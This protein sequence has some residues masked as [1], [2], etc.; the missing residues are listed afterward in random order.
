MAKLFL[1]ALGLGAGA[2]LML[3]RGRRISGL[4]GLESREGIM[5]SPFFVNCTFD[6]KAFDDSMELF[7]N[8]TD[9]SEERRKSM[10]RRSAS[11]C[12]WGCVDDS[13]VRVA[14]FRNRDNHDEFA[15]LAKSAKG[16]GGWQMSW[17][18]A[19]GPS[20]DSPRKTQCEAIKML[21]SG[22][23]YN[24]STAWIDGQPMSNWYL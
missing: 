4:S 19:L 1:V 22:F 8:M 7:S 23:R 12:V 2:Y 20:G 3:W 5:G 18:D 14:Q 10:A 24:G 21:S 9:S 16:D 11:R 15:I 13:E 17:F 6:Q